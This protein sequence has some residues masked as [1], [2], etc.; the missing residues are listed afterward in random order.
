MGR[1][2]GKQE[3]KQGWVKGGERKWAKKGKGG[4]EGHGDEEGEKRFKKTPGKKGK[5]LRP[6]LPARGH[7]DRK[8]ALKPS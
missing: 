4:R 5:C 7:A 8:E 1:R 2:N 6:R 3:G